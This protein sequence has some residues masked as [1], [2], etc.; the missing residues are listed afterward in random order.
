MRIALAF[1]FLLLGTACQVSEVPVHTQSQAQSTAAKAAPAAHEWRRAYPH[2]GGATARTAVTTAAVTQCADAKALTLYRFIDGIDNCMQLMSSSDIA[3]LGDLFAVNI[4]AKGMGD[5]A[6]WPNTVETVVSLTAAIPNFAANQKSYM[7]GEGTQIT[8]AVAPRDASRNLRYVVS[9]GATASPTVFLSAAPTGTHPGSPPSFLQVIGY[10]QQ[11]NVFNYY[12]FVSNPGQPTRTWAFA[13]NSSNARNPQTAGRGCM[14]C[15][16]NGALN[17]KELVPPWNNWGSSSASIS[18]ANIPAAVVSDPLYALLSTAALL[19]GNFQS[20]QTRYSQGLVTQSISSGKVSGVSALLRRLITT[21]TVNFSAST[22]ATSTTIQVPTEFFLQLLTLGTSQINLSFTAPSSFTM[23]TAAH[24]AFISANAF[25]LQQL[26]GSGS[27]VY[28]QPGT[29]FSPLFVP[30]SAY[31][32]QAMVQQLI[33]QKVIDANFA[34]SVLLVDFPNPVFSAKR[35]SLMTYANQIQTAT[36]L[37]T[38]ANPNGVPAQF[39]AL[40]QA[41]ANTQPACDTTRLLLCTPEQ[42]FLFYAGQ[43]DWQTRAR[44]QVNPYLAA[45]VQRLGTTAGVNDYMTLWASRQAQFAASPSVGSLNE[46]ALLLPCNSLP[47][48]TCKRMNPDGTISDDPLSSCVAQ[49]CVQSP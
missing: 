23:P 13:G 9:W 26:D 27:I 30:V 17:M 45:I 28:R 10:D 34:A 31:E 4:L 7:L 8:T 40:V 39:V 16:I 42:Q 19:Q 2:R 48:D 14:Q 15:H 47:L 18:A 20:L 38:G 5:A 43:S 21:S 49:T 32:D 6:K 1:A 46:F 11:K 3:A 36:V 37:D 35:D 29:T 44:N 25:A 41:A 24:N 22:A 33:N 12:E